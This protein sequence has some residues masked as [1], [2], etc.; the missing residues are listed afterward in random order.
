MVVCTWYNRL[1]GSR[2]FF[3][4]DMEFRDNDVQLKTLHD[5]VDRNTASGRM[6]ESLLVAMKTFENEQ[7]G[8][9]VFTKM[10]QRKE[11]GMWNGS[12]IPFGFRKDKDTD[13]LLPD[14][15]KADLLQSIFR[16]F[17]E[18]HAQTTKCA[19][20]SRHIRYLPPLGNRYG[21]WAPYITFWA[22][23]VTLGSSK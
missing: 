11:K 2:E 9:K 15:D 4:L 8:E 20:G 1:I 5:P 6:M 18:K 7:T 3:H 19:L 22:V 17:A 14:P 13:I 21:H 10:Q 12:H 23:N 16:V